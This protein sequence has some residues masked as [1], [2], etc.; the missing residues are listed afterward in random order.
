MQYAVN[1]CVCAH[2]VGRDQMNMLSKWNIFF[3]QEH[4]FRPKYVFVQSIRHPLIF[5]PEN[6]T[7]WIILFKFYNVD[8]PSNKYS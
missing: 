5:I 4:I 1:A 7:C 6:I 3:V 2:C 8:K